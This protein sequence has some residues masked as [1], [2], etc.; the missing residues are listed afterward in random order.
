MKTQQKQL[1]LGHDRSTGKFQRISVN[2]SGELIV[3][4]TSQDTQLQSLNDK[5]GVD[6]SDSPQSLT[7]LTRNQ[8]DIID[9]RLTTVVNFLDKDGGT[10]HL[11]LLN[12][13]VAN[14][15]TENATHLGAIDSSVDDVKTSVDNLN[16]KIG[17][18]T[19]SSPQS[20]T[21][22]LR[23]Q[24]DVIDSK[25]GSLI[26]FLDSLEGRARASAGSALKVDIVSGGGGDASAVNQILQTSHIAL[27]ESGTSSA[28]ITVANGAS[29]TTKN[30]TLS[31]IRTA[32]VEPSM[33]QILYTD[34]AP[35]GSG[36]A[37][38]FEMS[39][40]GGSTYSTLP[41]GNLQG[42]AKST[43]FGNLGDG[44]FDLTLLGTHFRFKITNNTGSSSN[45]TISLAAYGM[46]F[47]QA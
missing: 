9:N 7:A 10:S 43:L 33:I 5:I 32:L 36:T 8:K 11:S 38:D 12:D 19:S 15:L 26:V 35:G 30:I 21:A 28:T 22:L 24:K 47:T 46:T 6:Y 25:L 39:F 20:L 45:Y 23:N 34:S 31:D 18:D 42:V 14:L 17:T 3:N 29:A 27:Q 4:D 37:I 44:A 1:I 2:S 40:D 13:K 16:T 41:I